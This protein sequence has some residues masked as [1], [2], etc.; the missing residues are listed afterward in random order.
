MKTY[1][2]LAARV[3]PNGV[4]AQGS[5]PFHHGS[6]SPK[7]KQGDFDPEVFAA[8]RSSWGQRPR[9]SGVGKVLREVEE[10]RVPSCKR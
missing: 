2:H 9:A 1:D 8:S 3:N 10:V 6:A 7:P 5:P 4:A